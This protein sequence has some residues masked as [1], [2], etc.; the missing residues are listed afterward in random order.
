MRIKKIINLGYTD[1]RLSQTSQEVSI[2]V[3]GKG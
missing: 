1:D 2:T 3:G